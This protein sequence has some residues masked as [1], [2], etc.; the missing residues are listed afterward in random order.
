[1]P[2]WRLRALAEEATEPNRAAMR[3]YQRYKAIGSFPADELVAWYSGLI[4]EAE[5]AYERSKLDGNGAKL[6]A[7]FDLML[8]RFQSGR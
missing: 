3:A 2:R 6:D 1:L 8:L 4:R 7:V 5:D